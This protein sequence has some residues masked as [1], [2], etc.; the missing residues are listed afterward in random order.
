M[1]FLVR[2][3]I[4]HNQP[5]ISRGF[6]AQSQASGRANPTHELGRLAERALP[7]RR[8]ASAVYY[9]LGLTSTDPA[10]TTSC[11]PSPANAAGHGKLHRLGNGCISPSA[12][13]HIHRINSGTRCNQLLKRFRVGRISHWRDDIERGRSGLAVEQGGRCRTICREKNERFRQ[14]P[15]ARKL[16][17]TKRIK[18]R[19]LLACR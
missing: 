5:L 18:P 1:A 11:S 12:I 14:A 15:R 10:A 8:A 4:F 3:R 17:C 13:L 16:Q 19:G 2:R 9:V 6:L 7:L